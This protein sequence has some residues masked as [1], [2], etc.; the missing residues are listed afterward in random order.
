M[1]VI[2]YGTGR[3][4]TQSLASF[5]N[6]Q[7]GFKVTHER[8]PLGWVPTLGDN[9]ED[10][11]RDFANEVHDGRLK[12]VG[13]ISYVWIN[14]IAYVVKHYKFAKLINITRD[15]DEVIESFWTYKAVIRTFASFM[16]NEWFGHPYNSDKPTKDAIARTV[17]FYR[18]W[19][20]EYIKWFPEV[21]YQMDVNDL[22]DEDKLHNLLT[23]L[24]VDCKRN[25]ATQHID[26]KR[27]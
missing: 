17:K 6:Q 26:R 19:E 21:I 16:E 1:I 24:W 13:D 3:C 12:A 15:D 27:I 18:Y 4:G 20:K 11:I 5:L 2:G 9:R 22:N 25:M 14:H 23:W 7:Q 10:V 8:V